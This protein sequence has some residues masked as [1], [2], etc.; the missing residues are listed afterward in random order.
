M[1]LKMLWPNAA[2]FGPPFGLD[3]LPELH[4]LNAH[5]GNKADFQRSDRINMETNT[6][7]LKGA[8]MTVLPAKASEVNL[9]ELPPL[10][11]F[12]M[13]FITVGMEIHSLMVN[14]YTG[15]IRSWNTGT[16]G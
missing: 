10:N 2:S 14:I 8:G 5:S 16:L 6:K 1:G 3:L 15:I 12:Y 11:Y 7:A 4:P 13:H 9:E